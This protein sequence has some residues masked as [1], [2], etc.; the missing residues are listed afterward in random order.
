MLFFCPTRFAMGESYSNHGYY[1]N[2]AANVRVM[3]APSRRSPWDPQLPNPEFEGLKK[4]SYF[5]YHDMIGA[6]F[7]AYGH[8]A[9]PG[10]SAS[11]ISFVHN[12]CTNILFLGGDVPSY[13]RDSVAVKRVMLND[14]VQIGP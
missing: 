1:T 7:E 3:C 5:K 8:V 14:D 9:S 11:G 10:T 6:I 12:E 4:F 2:Y 13:K